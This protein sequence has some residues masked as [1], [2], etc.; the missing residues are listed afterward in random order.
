[1]TKL[2]YSEVSG[3]PAAT[4]SS[5]NTGA[6]SQLATQLASTPQYDGVTIEQMVGNPLYDRIPT[7][8]KIGQAQ[9]RIAES[10]KILESKPKLLRGLN[11]MYQKQHK[12]KTEK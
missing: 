2:P 12:P 11:D 4:S 9:K 7:I 5:S 1:M 10:A 6:A 3:E 8:D